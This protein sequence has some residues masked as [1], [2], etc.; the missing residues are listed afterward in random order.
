MPGWTS[1]RRSARATGRL[2]VVL[3]ALCALFYAITIVRMTAGMTHASP[4]ACRTQQ[5]HDS[6]LLLA[7]VVAGMVGLVVRLGAA[8]PPVL[9]GHR[10][11]RHAAGRPR[12]RRRSHADAFVTVRFNA[13]TTPDLP[14][15]SAR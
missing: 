15:T 12:P 7:V 2:L 8:L 13:K 6:C 14:G 5:R 11:W 9:R 10:L 3:L 1:A 4:S